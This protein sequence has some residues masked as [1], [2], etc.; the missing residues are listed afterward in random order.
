MVNWELIRDQDADWGLW[1]GCAS[2]GLGA[3]VVHTALRGEVLALPRSPAAQGMGIILK[4]AVIFVLSEGLCLKNCADLHSR[5]GV[6]A[7]SSAE[8]AVEIPRVLDAER[9][10]G[11][12]PLA[13]TV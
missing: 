9:G 6:G 13:L 1:R 12:K 8:E 2:F 7:V 3:H 10:I 4:L 11:M 5:F